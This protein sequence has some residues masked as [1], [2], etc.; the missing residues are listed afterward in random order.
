MNHKFRYPCTGHVDHQGFGRFLERELGAPRANLGALFSEL[1]SAFGARNL[2]LVNSG[3][4]ANLA[5]ALALAEATGR[6]MHAITAGFTFPTTLSSLLFAGYSVTVVDIE[7]SGFGIDPD[8][9]LRAIQP[10]TRVVCLTH[11]LGFP[12]R[13][14]DV[15]AI[16]QEHGLL[17]LQDACE[18]MDLEIEGRPVHSFGTL[19]TWSFYHPHHLS[20]Y[21]GGAIIAP[22]LEWHDR[23]ESIVHWGRECMCHYAP[24]RCKAPEGMHHHF[25]YA[26][27]GFNLEMSEL[28]A[29]FGRFQLRGWKEQESL[30]RR[31][32]AILYEAVSGIPGVR[33]R[34][35]PRGLG[36]PFAFPITVE[37]RPLDLVARRLRDRGVEVRNFVG[38]LVTQHAAFSAVPHDGLS[39]AKALFETSFIV[40]IHQTLVEPDVRDVAMILREELTT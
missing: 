38:G 16:A 24:E 19:T 25:S 27:P 1:S 11:L 2:T 14:M 31:N 33:V 26:R 12:A 7:P 37:D 21:G 18:T 34:S 10:N 9:L 23:L 3:S 29:C 8:A 13:L 20:T 15:M 5:A 32:Y 30:R 4:S 6:G 22:D 40:G 39:R 35:A 36:S 17:V 28:N